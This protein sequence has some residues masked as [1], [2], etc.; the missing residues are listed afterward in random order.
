MASTCI[1]SPSNWPTAATL[2]LLPRAPRT[3]GAAASFVYR[4]FDPAARPPMPSPARQRELARQFPDAML[5]CFP[6]SAGQIERDFKWLGSYRYGIVHLGGR[7]QADLAATLQGRQRIARLARAL[8]AIRRRYPG[9]VTAA[10]TNPFPG[11]FPM[12]I[13]RLRK[14]CCSRSPRQSSSAAAAP[15]WRRILTARIRR[16]MPWPRE[17]KAGCC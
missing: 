14:S 16:S 4:S 6:K 15:S 5:F 9:T 17:M 2:P 13:R 12:N 3:A 8:L 11:A 10:H 7:D 1:A